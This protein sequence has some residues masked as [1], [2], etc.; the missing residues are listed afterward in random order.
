MDH[1]RELHRVLGLRTRQGLRCSGGWPAQPRQLAGAGPPGPVAT[2]RV[3][4]GHGASQQQ[5]QLAFAALQ[6]RAI[7]TGSSPGSVAR[8]RSP[9]RSRTPAS[10][11]LSI[12][13]SKCCAFIQPARKA[14]RLPPRNAAPSVES[15]VALHV[16]GFKSFLPTSCEGYECAGLL[17]RSEI[18]TRAAAATARLRSRNEESPCSDRGPMGIPSSA[19]EGSPHSC[20]MS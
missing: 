3:N 10:R 18:H 19:Q 14:I 6:A 8:T 7:H 16:V 9:P 4:G 1:R 11:G 13:T 20:S 12:R 17:A 15:V 2:S 5:R